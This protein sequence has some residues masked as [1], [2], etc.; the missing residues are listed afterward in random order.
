MSAP[1][2]IKPRGARILRPRGG[3]GFS[4]G[5]LRTRQERQD[6]VRLRTAQESCAVKLARIISEI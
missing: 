1:P 5:Y 4:Y 6:N 2:L 3:G